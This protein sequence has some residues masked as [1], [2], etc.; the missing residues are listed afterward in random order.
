VAWHDLPLPFHPQ[1][2]PAA[3]AA[4]EVYAQKGAAAFWT[5]HDALLSSQPN[6][7][8]AHLEE[9]AQSLGVLMAKFETAIDAVASD[10][11]VAAAHAEEIS[12]TPAF[13]VAAVHA[14]EG[15]F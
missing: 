10:A 6:L 4:R 15:T 14:T 1:A 8:R 2:L 7:D 5:M 3:R 11:D 12:G 9:R 13:V